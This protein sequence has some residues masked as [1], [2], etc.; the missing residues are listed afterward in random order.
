MINHPNPDDPYVTMFVPISPLWE[1]TLGQAISEFG[2]TS[3]ASV[4][5]MKLN[6][7]LRSYFPYLMSIH[8]LSRPLNIPSI[9]VMVDSP[10]APTIA[11]LSAHTTTHTNLLEISQSSLNPTLNPSLRN[12]SMP[13]DFS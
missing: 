8:L 4:S 7:N 6:P 10:H 5:S 9:Q 11:I 12:A 2:A 3:A 1:T 13:C